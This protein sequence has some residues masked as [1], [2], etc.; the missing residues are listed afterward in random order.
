MTD[1][2][3]V[4]VAGGGLAGITAACELADAGVRVKLIEKRPFLGGRSYSYEADGVE[5]DNGQHVFL[6]C[7]TAYIALL[8]RLGVRDGV[9]LQRRFRVPV[10]DRIR[11]ESVLQSASLPPPAHLMPSLLRFKSLSLREKALAT[12][13]FAQMRSTDLARHPEL[14]DITFEQW[15]LDRRQSRNAINSLWN[16]IVQPTLNDHASRVSAALALMVFQEGFLRTSDG[17]NVGWAKMGLSSLLAGAAREYIESRG[18]EIMTTVALH[19]LE[20][21]AAGISRALTSAGEFTADAYVI[22]LTP[23]DVPAVLPDAV[24]DDRFFARIGEI[25]ASPIVN[26]HLWYERPVWDRAFAAFLN[27]PVQWVFNKSKLWRQDGP[28]Y[29]DISLSG[30]HEWIDVPAA[31]IRDQFE[32]EIQVLFPAARDVGLVRALVVKQRE[33]TFS[34]QPGVA[35]LRPTQGTPVRNLFLAGDWTDTGWPAT[36]ESAVRSGA[37]AAMEAMRSLVRSERQV[38]EA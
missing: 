7:C 10:I 8:E 29:L 13:A 11:G 6:G 16:L 23:G 24:R 3:V 31:E 19:G 35:R 22:A 34:A 4:F 12:F 30:A 27:T 33:A 1:R 37:S 15:L 32:K 20:S 38:S 36:M 14:D 2:P 26:V 17:A 5:V 28:Q 21:D 18:G 9:H 25:G